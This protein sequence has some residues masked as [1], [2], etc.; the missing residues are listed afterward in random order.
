MSKAGYVIIGYTPEQTAE[1]REGTA[2]RK[3]G[4]KRAKPKQISGVIETHSGAIAYADLV[5][6]QGGEVTDVRATITPKAKSR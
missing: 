6:K 5:R 4:V 1:W 3:P 2:E